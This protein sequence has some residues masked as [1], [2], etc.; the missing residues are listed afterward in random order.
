MR[1]TRTSSADAQNR[2]ACRLSGHA[3]RQAVAREAI[4]CLLWGDKKDTSAR[5]SLSQ[6]ISDV[7][8]TFGDGSSAWILSSSGV[9]ATRPR[10]TPCSSPIWCEGT[11]PK[12]TSGRRAPLRRRISPG[13]RFVPGGFRLLGSGERER[14]RHLAHSAMG[15]CSRSGCAE[16]SSR[17]AQHRPKKS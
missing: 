14:L 16:R 2:S 8:H 9:P 6:A 5:H 4:A 7:R 17:L 13:L 11:A 3:S 15:N 12:K 1:R 10:L